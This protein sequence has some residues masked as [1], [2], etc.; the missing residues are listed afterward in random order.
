MAMD[1]SLLLAY[2]SKNFVGLL[3]CAAV[4]IGVRIALAALNVG[5]KYQRAFAA[6]IVFLAAVVG[7]ELLAFLIA[8]S[9]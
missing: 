2:S 7:W 3:L 9:M 1:E 8:T 5:T 4:A 6:L